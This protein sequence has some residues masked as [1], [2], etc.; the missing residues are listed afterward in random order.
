VVHGILGYSIMTAS[1]QIGFGAGLA[2]VLAVIATTALAGV[3][4]VYVERPTQ[5][6]GKSLAMRYSTPAQPCAD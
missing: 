1:L 6:F 3:L 4:H 2:L 5:I